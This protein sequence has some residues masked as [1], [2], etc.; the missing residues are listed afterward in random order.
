M[1]AKLV[2]GAHA[3]TTNAHKIYVLD[4]FSHT[5]AKGSHGYIRKENK[6]NSFNISAADAHLVYWI[7]INTT[8]PICQKQMHT[9]RIGQNMIWEDGRLE[10]EVSPHWLQHVLG[11]L[12]P[13][14]G[15]PASHLISKLGC[16]RRRGVQRVIEEQT[17]WIRLDHQLSNR[18]HMEIFNTWR[19][20]RNYSW[21]NPKLEIFKIAKPKQSCLRSTNKAVDINLAKVMYGGHAPCGN[22]LAGCLF[23]SITDLA[24]M[25]NQ[26][27]TLKAGVLDHFLAIWDRNSQLWCLASGVLFQWSMPNSPAAMVPGIAKCLAHISTALNFLVCVSKGLACAG[28]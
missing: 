1:H 27:E 26:R 7:D 17:R 5:R 18:T 9:N 28:W 13:K 4:S 6:N 14:G 21:A 22:A 25:K 2:K 8:T 12:L 20:V 24:D 3:R 15:Q 23:V 10:L 11:R 19:M 16:C